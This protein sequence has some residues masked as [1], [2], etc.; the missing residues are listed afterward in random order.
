MATATAS[1]KEAKRRFSVILN[2]KMEADNYIRGA[3][4]PIT[5]VSGHT[6]P[7]RE[8]LCRFRNGEG[9]NRFTVEDWLR[10]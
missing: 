2:E 8:H 5:N 4:N 9:G 7:I 3:A 10:W 6:D 1:A